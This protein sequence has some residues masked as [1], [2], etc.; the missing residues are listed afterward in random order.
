MKK[1]IGILPIVGIVI[2]SLLVL[3]VGVGATYA[4]FSGNRLVRSSLVTA[5]TGSGEI[6][7]QISSYGGDDFRDSEEANLIQVNDTDVEFLL[8]VSTADLRTFL[9]DS[10]SSNGNAIGF[11]E[12][13]NEADYYHGRI[14][15][16]AS[17]NDMEQDGRMALYLDESTGNGGNIVSNATAEMLNASRLGLYIQETGSAYIFSLS[18]ENN[19]AGEQVR[20]TFLNGTQLEEGQVLT[21]RDGSVVAVEDPAVPINS[22]AIAF[23][24]NQVTVPDNPVL[25]MD[26]NAIYTI[27]V[28]FYLE[29]CDPDCSDSVEFNEADLHLGFYGVLTHE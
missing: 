18:D 2:S 13:E 19:E 22:Y 27:D 3:S 17:G 21:K 28:Y 14:Y 11:S 20:N 29:G 6:K 5:T 26:F 15:L 8:P 23:N 16:R 10:S 7:L 12:V 1:K 4:W 25:Y 9:Y 24:E